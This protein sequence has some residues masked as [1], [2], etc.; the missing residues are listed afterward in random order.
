MLDRVARLPVWPLPTAFRPQP[1]DVGEAAEAIAEYAT[2]DAAGRVPDIG[3]PNVSTVRELATAYR[4][5]RGLR[6]PIVRLPLPGDVASAFRAGAATC[7]DRDVGTV[8]WEEWLDAQ[9]AI[10]DRDIY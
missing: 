6:R 7:P 10:P 1:I 4:K 9:E 8:T 2:V 5:H 3:G